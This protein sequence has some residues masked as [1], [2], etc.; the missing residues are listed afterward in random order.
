MRWLSVSTCSVSVHYYKEESLLRS[1]F[2]AVTSESRRAQFLAAFSAVF[3]ALG[4]ASFGRPSTAQAT[5]SADCNTYIQS[6]T[7]QN[8]AVSRANTYYG[9][10]GWSKASPWYVLQSQGNTWG[11]DYS[12]TGNYRG[13][14]Q[15]LLAPVL[16]GRSPLLVAAHTRQ[17]RLPALSFLKHRK[18]F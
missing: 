5:N 14:V 13:T 2:V 4:A 18:P 15:G 16:S 3:I 10:G 8:D 11:G 7:I 12:C 9:P 1:I 6:T 17:L